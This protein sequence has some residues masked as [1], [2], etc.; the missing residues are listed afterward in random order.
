MC[1]LMQLTDWIQMHKR[2]HQSSVFLSSWSGS[3]VGSIMNQVEWCLQT[4]YIHLE[5]QNVTYLEM[6]SLHM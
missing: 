1:W 3:Y 4:I 6:G 5:L 2:C